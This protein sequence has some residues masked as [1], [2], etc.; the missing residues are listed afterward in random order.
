MILLRIMK[1]LIKKLILLFFTINLFLNQK[2]F[3]LWIFAIAMKRSLYNTCFL[4]GDN[5]IIFNART[6]ALAKPSL[7]EI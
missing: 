1:N 6:N 7:V 5:T 2:E 4:N 3:F